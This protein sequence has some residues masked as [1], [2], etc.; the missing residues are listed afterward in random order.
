MIV[1]ADDLHGLSHRLV[2][3]IRSCPAHRHRETGSSARAWLT[4]STLATSMASKLRTIISSAGEVSAGHQFQV[5]RFQAML[6][7]HEFSKID[8]FVGL[9]FRDRYTG[10]SPQ[11][12]PLMGI[13]WVGAAAI[14]PGSARMA[15]QVVPDTV[16]CWSTLESNRLVMN[17]AVLAS[18]S[19]AGSCDVSGTLTN[20]KGRVG[21]DGQRE[22]NLQCD[23]VKR[24]AC[25]AAGSE[26]WV[27]CLS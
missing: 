7:D 26:K 20:D 25:C 13:D 19:P 24:P 27:R 17:I 4:I 8:G 3:P 9:H 21:H 22:R 1:D 23:Q 14:T 16:G 6:V 15:V 5:E 12:L 11:P 2:H 18:S 10:F